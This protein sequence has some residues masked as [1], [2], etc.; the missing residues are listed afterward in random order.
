[1]ILIFDLWSY[2]LRKIKD[3]D[4]RSLPGSWSLIFDLDLIPSDLSMRSSCCKPF[5]GHEVHIFCGP[6]VADMRQNNN[7]V[8]VVKEQ[9]DIVQSHSIPHVWEKY[10]QRSEKRQGC[11]LS[12]SQAE[13]GSSLLVLCL[14]SKIMILI[15]DLNRI[16]D[17]RSRSW[18]WSLIY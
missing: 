10:V 18:S 11:L 14:F 16:K 17:Q 9:S 7:W 12:Y 2:C 5:Y 1:M 15:L 6:V 3:Q 4:P 13:P 8:E